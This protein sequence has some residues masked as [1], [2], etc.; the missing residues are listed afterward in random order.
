MKKEES[1]QLFSELYRHTPTYQK[2]AIEI[3][4]DILR[5]RTVA[6]RE[7]EDIIICAQRYQ[8]IL[9]S[10]GYSAKIVPT[11]ND[12]SPVVYGEKNVGADTTLMFYRHYD[13]QPEGSINDWLSSPWELTERD[14]RLYG[15][16]VADNKGH[17][18]MALMAIQLIE[19]QY[20]ELPINIK[21]ICE[22]EEEAG[23]KNLPYF[24][25]KNER[26]MKADV[27]IWEFAS[28]YLDEKNPLIDD[29]PNLKGPF[30]IDCGL[31][32][33]AYFELE[34]GK[35]KIF[36]NRDVHSGEAAAVPNAAWR[37]AWALNTLKDQNEN[38][39]VEGF[40]ELVER[41]SDEDIEVLKEVD[42]DPA[43][44]YLI[45]YELDDTLLGRRGL[46][47]NIELQLKPSLTIC[48]LDSGHT[49]QGAKTIVPS[50]ALSKLDFRLVPNLTSS[51]VEILLKKHLHNNG[52]DDIEVRLLNGY[53]PAK[54]PVSHPFIKKVRSITQDLIDPIKVNI[55]PLAPGSGPAYLFTP[56][57]AIFMGTN[58]IYGLNGHAPNENLPKSIFASGIA[59]NAY[60]LQMLKGWRK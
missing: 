30:N 17:F 53:E 35:P 23:S 50:K 25:E 27:C 29:K 36:P 21:F 20:D 1:Q 16:G 34:A 15:R 45:D 13:V 39:L 11:S 58:P 56:H 57:T 55:T 52:F 43:D 9:L 60:L 10:Y 59:Y 46:V 32:G 28:V 47:L 2:K 6:F 49:G 18:V 12:G 4:R 8:E 24:T 7:P 38:I 5:F 51:K 3:L 37:M 33:V 31:K 40:N 44:G 42:Y 14:S 19:E 48:G 22:G 41:P 54:T 26:L